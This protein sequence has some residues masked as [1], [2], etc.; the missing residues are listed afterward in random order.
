MVCY[1]HD[2]LWLFVIIYFFQSKFMLSI[3]KLFKVTN[4]TIIEWANILNKIYQSNFHWTLIKKLVGR[5][6][7][8]Q[9]PKFLLFYSYLSNIIYNIYIISNENYLSNCL[10]F[11]LHTQLIH[12]FKRGCSVLHLKYLYLIQEYDLI[13][14]DII[15]SSHSYQ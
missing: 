2:W 10:F 9:L 5:I 6:F 1:W 8:H 15:L 13:E 7:S 12:K 4:Q 14:F 3:T 11:I